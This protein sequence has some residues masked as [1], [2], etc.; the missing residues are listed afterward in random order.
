MG[1]SA[2]LRSFD[3]GVVLSSH[4]VGFLREVCEV[5]YVVGGGSVERYDAG[6]DSY[7][8]MLTKRIEMS[9]SSLD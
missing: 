7:V 2:A 8:S 1:L 4:D 5:I 6:V 3:G 9:N